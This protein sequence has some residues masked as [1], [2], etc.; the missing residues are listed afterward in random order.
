MITFGFGKIDVAQQWP[1]QDS[2]RPFLAGA[3]ILAR[4]KLN[5]GANEEY[6]PSRVAPVQM[7]T[8][9]WVD[10]NCHNTPTLAHTQSLLGV[11]TTRREKAMR[12]RLQLRRKSITKFIILV[13]HPVSCWPFPSA[14]C[15]VDTDR[16][17]RY[18]QQQQQQE[19]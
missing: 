13:E 10:M 9:A 17:N 18:R 19:E 16:K 8:C 14:H 2:Q 6:L 7:C 11:P 3:T 4:P 5:Q 1:H 15:L 12:Y